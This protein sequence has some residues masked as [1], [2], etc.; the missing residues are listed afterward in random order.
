MT[1]DRQLLQRYVSEGS[2]E[3]FTEIVRQHTGLVYSAA[4]RQVRDPDL[5]WDI[6][7]NVFIHLAQKARTI[8]SGMVLAGWLHRDTRFTAL[9]LIRAENRRARR[10]QEATLMN[11]SDPPDW[12]NIRPLLDEALQ[13]L[14]PTDRDALLL[15]FFE[16]QDLAA[17]GVALGSSADAARKRVE[18]AM[19]RLRDLLVKRGITTTGAAL[20]VVL[21]AHA[22]EVVPEGLTLSLVSGSSAA[23]STAAASGTGSS[24]ANVFIMAKSKILVGALVVAGAATPLLLQQRAVATARTEHA[25]LVTS[26]QGLEAASTSGDQGTTEQ[27]VATDSDPGAIQAESDELKRLRTEVAALQASVARLRPTAARTIAKTPRAGKHSPALATFHFKDL[28]DVGQ[29]TA[30]ALLETEMRA[31]LHGDTNRLMQLIA[32][33]PDTDMQAVQATLEALKNEAEQGLEKAIAKAEADASEFRLL[34]EEPAEG[35]DRWLVCEI[36]TDDGRYDKV[37]IRVRSTSSGWKMVMGRDGQPLQEHLETLD[38]SSE[39]TEE[40]K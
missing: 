4:L 8:P 33:E 37:R 14:G 21:S 32:F 17:V 23:I 34:A 16:Q 7:Q 19:E 22:V 11:S 2:E 25:A 39:T 3:A 28:R 35:L 20:G 12:E 24:V 30:A 27:T 9:D 29:A 36:I 31:L 38:G 13:E 18:R 15:R 26:T 10:E 6:A 5:A 40:A 1:D